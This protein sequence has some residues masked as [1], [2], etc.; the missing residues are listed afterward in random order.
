MQGAPGTTLPR[1]PNYSGITLAKVEVNFHTDTF[2]LC[3]AKIT[4]NAVMYA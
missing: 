4:A 2:T 3:A 1:A